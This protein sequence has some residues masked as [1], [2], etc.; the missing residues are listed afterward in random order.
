MPSRSQFLATKE[1]VT[2]KFRPTGPDPVV[3]AFEGSGR[4]A[5]G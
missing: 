3:P 5:A 4:A 2:K 1:T